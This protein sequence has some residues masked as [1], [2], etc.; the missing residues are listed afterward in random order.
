MSV[1]G[2][3]GLTNSTVGGYIVILVALAPRA[4]YY[5][6]DSFHSSGADLVPPGPQRPVG[7]RERRNVNNHRSSEDPGDS[8]RVNTS[9]F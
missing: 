4:P 5:P 8:T 7:S 3:L 2:S 9:D 6:G 1:C